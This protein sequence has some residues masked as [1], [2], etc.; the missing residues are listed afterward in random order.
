MKKR[1]RTNRTK[2]TGTEGGGRK[3][4]PLERM[5]KIYAQLQDGKFPNCSTLAK[6]FEVARKTVKRD[7]DFMRDRMAPTTRRACATA[8][9]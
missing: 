5:K 8:G 2:R 6:E 3:R 9:R 7:L 1:K 4:P